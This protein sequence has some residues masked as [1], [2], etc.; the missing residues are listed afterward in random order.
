M[1]GKVEGSQRLSVSSEKLSAIR[2]AEALPQF[3]EVR[4]SGL[5]RQRV[6]LPCA[7]QAALALRITPVPN[8]RDKFLAP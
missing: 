5:A 3:V 7:E 6:A 1:G 4:S 2:R 8:H